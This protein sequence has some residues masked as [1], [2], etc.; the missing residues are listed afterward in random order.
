[1]KMRGP[2]LLLM[3]GAVMMIDID[4]RHADEMLARNASSAEVTHRD[5]R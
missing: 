5:T 4:E 2:R 3:I 1:M